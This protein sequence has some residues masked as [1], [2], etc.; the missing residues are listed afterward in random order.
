[1]VPLYVYTAFR[2]LEAQLSETMR[3]IFKGT[4]TG[5]DYVCPNCN[6]KRYTL[7]LH[8]DSKVSENMY[9]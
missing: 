5:E 6:R 3:N 7:T 9:M 2:S 1:M 4:K 8:S